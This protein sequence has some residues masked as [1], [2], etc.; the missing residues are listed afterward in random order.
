MNKI[1]LLI[2]V[3]SLMLA[4]LAGTFLPLVPGLPLI[5]LA[6][7]VYGFFTGWIDYGFNFMLVW[8]IITL[9]LMFLDY[10][11]GALGAKKYGASPAGIWGAIIGG[12]LGVIF[13]GFLG[14]IAGPFLG[15]FVGELLSGKTHTS[16]LRSSWGTFVGY[17]AGSLFKVIIGLIMIGSFIWQV[18][19]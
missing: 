17:L 6:F 13:L 14:I 19:R 3:S 7:L 9:L 4:G 1:I 10:Y 16:A 5:Y 11:T 18:W 15:A 8:G 2:I 12:F